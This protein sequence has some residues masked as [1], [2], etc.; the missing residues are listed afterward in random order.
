MTDPLQITLSVVDQSPIRKGGTPSEALWESVGLA[1]H[2][3]NVGY[4]RYWVAEH[5]SAGT[6]AGPPRGGTRSRQRSVSRV[7]RAA[8]GARC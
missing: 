4:S 3:E 6:F 8:P 1:Q 7:L 2:V 5:H